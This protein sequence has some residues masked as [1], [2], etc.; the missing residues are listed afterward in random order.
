[1]CGV[2]VRVWEGRTREVCVCVRVS[3]L[4]K[5]PVNELLY[6]GQQC[7]VESLAG[8][9]HLFNGPTRE[10]NTNRHLIR[11]KRKMLQQH[12]TRDMMRRN[13]PADVRLNV[14]LYV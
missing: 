14:S 1:M 13:V 5:V 6:A 2:C 12:A 11:T 8:A 3:I 4:K 10:M 9:A 7:E